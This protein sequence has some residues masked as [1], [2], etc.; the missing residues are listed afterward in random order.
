MTTLRDNDILLVVG[1][2]KIWKTDIARFH[3]FEVPHDVMGINHAAL[4]LD[5]EPKHAF[6]YHPD[7]ME[8]VKQQ[9]PGI[10]THSLR[11]SGGVDHYWR[12]R[13]ETGRV[14]FLFGL[15]PGPGIPGV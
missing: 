4:W 8:M 1:K 6:S 14:I 10:I 7:I 9:R 12:I 5:A 15:P 2:S 13:G 11:P 3:E